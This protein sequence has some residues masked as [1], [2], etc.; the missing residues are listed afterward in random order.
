MKNPT[1]IWHVGKVKI[2]R[3][4][5]QENGGWPPDLIFAGLTADRVKSIAWLYPNYADPDGSLRVSIHA[6]VIESQGRQIIV[7]TCVGNDKP[8]VIQQWDHLNLPFLERLNWAGFPPEQIDVVLC[9]HMH[10]DHVG[11]NTRW[12]GKDWMATFPNATYLF[13]RLEWE[14]WVNRDHGIGDMPKHIAH[15]AELDTGISDSITPIVKAGLHKLV[16]TNYRITDEVSFF[17]TPGHTPGH[18][19]VAINSN[20]KGAVIT[21]DIIHSPIQFADPGI[22]SNFDV[23]RAL[24]LATRQAFIGDHADRDILVLGTHFPTPSGGR[25]VSDNDTWCFI[26]QS[27]GKV[28][29]E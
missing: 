3:V 6:Y 19:S 29:K 27:S 25:V 10:L 13:A 16:E 26:E 12:D 7:D 17:A 14:H 23:D 21:G 20:G 1:D 24:G 8:R 18:V 4:V 2:T 11:W 28:T 22:C 9:T 5:E 15:L